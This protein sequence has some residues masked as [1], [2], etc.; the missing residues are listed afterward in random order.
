[1]QSRGVFDRNLKAKPEE[2]LSTFSFLFCEIVN[3]CRQLDPQQAEQH[4]SDIGYN[5]G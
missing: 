1:M 5:L 4:L 3:Y 2:N